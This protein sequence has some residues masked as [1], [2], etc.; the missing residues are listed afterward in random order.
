VLF[1]IVWLKLKRFRAGAG[2]HERR[3]SGFTLIELL[4]VLAIIAILAALLLPVLSRAKVAARSAACKSNARQLGIALALYAD[5]HAHYPYGADFDRGM[6]WYNS[7]S[8]YYGNNDKIMDCPAYRGDKGFMWAQNTILYQGGS[9]GYNGFGS[10]SSGHIYATS[11]DVLGLGGDRPYNAGPGALDPVPESK[12]R[13]PSDM[14]AIGDSMLTP[15]NV[16]SYLLTI[17]DGN[18]PDRERHNGGSN[19]AFCD[20]HVESSLNKRLVSTNE[21]ARRR[22]NNDH[23]PHLGD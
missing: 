5:D 15:W 6:L 3:L 14:I 20:G 18:T 17:A 4:V 11:A 12:V 9:Y 21:V 7:L 22:W 10:K 2:R 13:L 16:T 8:Q 19:V 1:V 23:E